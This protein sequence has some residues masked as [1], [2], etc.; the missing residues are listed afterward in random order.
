MTTDIALYEPRH[1]ITFWDETSVTV[2]SE[3]VPSINADLQNP[4]VTFIMIDGDTHHK[5]SIKNIRKA[6]QTVSELEALLS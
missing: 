6:V 5:N 2:K 4:A 1:I 3:H